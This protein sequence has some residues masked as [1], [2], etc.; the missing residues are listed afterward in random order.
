MFRSLKRIFRRADAT[1]SLH[2]E[3]EKIAREAIQKID[4]DNPAERVGVKLYFLLRKQFEL[5]GK[6]EGEFPFQPPFSTSKARGALLGT[7]IEL[8]RQEYGSTPDK[9][10]I[11][12]A[13]TAFTLAFGAA[14]GPRAAL[15]TIE[16]ASS[17][18]DEI[19]NTSDWAIKDIRETAG[20][21]SDAYFLAV[22]GMI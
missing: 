19:I 16:E 10:V 6:P 13:T 21:S 14:H 5:I 18:N 22:D 11:D 4:F 1:S 17:G 20:D 3:I 9:A 2:E 7:A 12:A 15:D 8:V